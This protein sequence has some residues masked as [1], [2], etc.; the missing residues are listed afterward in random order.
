MSKKKWFTHVSRDEGEEKLHISHLYEYVSAYCIGTG[1][2]DLLVELI[3]EALVKAKETMQAQIVD[4]D[5]EMCL[6][7]YPSGNLTL[8]IPWK[9]YKIIR[10]E[11]DGL[12]ESAVSTHGECCKG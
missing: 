8:M 1:D 2:L 11:E 9:C 7:V 6:H 4:R 12:G 5:G 10:E 3:E